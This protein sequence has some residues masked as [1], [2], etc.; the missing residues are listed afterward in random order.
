MKL[1]ERTLTVSNKFFA[2]RFS[3]VCALGDLEKTLIPEAM[4]ISLR[5][6]FLIGFTVSFCFLLIRQTQNLSNNPCALCAL[7]SRDSCLAV[8]HGLKVISLEHRHA[9]K[10]LFLTQNNMVEGLQGVVGKVVH[11]AEWKRFEIKANA[12]ILHP[13]YNCKWEQNHRVA[14]VNSHEDFCWKALLTSK[15][16]GKN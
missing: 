5:W 10:L 6:L 2:I 16:G 4:F 14:K 11:K 7:P 13:R 9:T 8:S 12:V 3:V 15:C 1:G